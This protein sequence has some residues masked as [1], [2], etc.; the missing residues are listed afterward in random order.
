LELLKKDQLA[1]HLIFKHKDNKNLKD[2]IK[3]VLNKIFNVHLKGV[4]KN[5]D[6]KIYLIDILSIN[7][8]L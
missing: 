3:E 5:T 6:K 2:N 1:L 4:Q 8:Q 7:I